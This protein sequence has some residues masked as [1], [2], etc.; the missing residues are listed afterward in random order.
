LEDQNCDGKME[1]IKIWE[2]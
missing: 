2:Y 1:L